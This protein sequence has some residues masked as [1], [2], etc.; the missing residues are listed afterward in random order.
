MKS[1]E[2]DACNLQFGSIFFLYLTACTLYTSLDSCGS[3]PPLFPPTLV[4]ASIVYLLILITNY[5]YVYVHIHTILYF[6]LRLQE[7][8]RRFP[9]SVI[10][11]S[12][13]DDFAC[14]VRL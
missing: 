10:T 4:I 5:S 12:V 2:F 3:M 7:D 11:Q 14:Y 9:V 1:V 6:S 13:F 8:F